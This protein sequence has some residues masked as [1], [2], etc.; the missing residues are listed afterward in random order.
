MTYERFSCLLEL[1][2]SDR[3]PPESLPEFFQA[4]DSGDFDAIVG[5]DMVR[6]IRRIREEDPGERSDTPLW[7]REMEQTTWEEMMA[8]LP[9]GPS[10]QPVRPIRWWKPA[11]AAAAVALL[12]IGAWLFMGR[13]PGHQL[14]RT[15][16]VPHTIPGNKAILTLGDGTRMVL[17]SMSNGTLATQGNV[18][19]I[20]L[21]NGQLSY[22]PAGN[23]AS[24]GAGPVVYNTME[25]PRG[26]Q[27]QLTLPD[28]TKV[29]L[30]SASTIHYPN[31]FAGTDRRVQITGEAYFE[32]AANAR[33]PFFVEARNMTVQVLGTEFDLMAYSDE[34]TVKTTLVSGGIRVSSGAAHR[35]LKPG[36]QA[37]LSGQTPVFTLSSPSLSE[38]LAWKEGKF[39][40]TNSGIQPMMRQIARWYDVNVVYQGQLPDVAFTGIFPR[41]ENVAELLEVL[42]EAGKVHFIIDGNTIV[43]TAAK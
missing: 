39:R 15:T 14:V 20:K 29:W 40:F 32:V 8:N 9:S 42:Q 26:G 30:N 11:V 25:T 41:K 31:R 36:Q 23:A 16:V 21:A 18:S 22:R 34:E 35:I 33:L 28:G 6:H 19:V 37:S 12:A 7:T 4:L 43:V 38:T 3:L 13:Q 24:D 27:Y 2:K 5:E 17:D 1:Y 10:L